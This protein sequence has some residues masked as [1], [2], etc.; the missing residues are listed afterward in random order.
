MLNFVEKGS[1][2]LLGAYCVYRCVFLLF[3]CCYQENKKFK[4]VDAKEVEGDVF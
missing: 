3:R 2:V 4:G 1:N